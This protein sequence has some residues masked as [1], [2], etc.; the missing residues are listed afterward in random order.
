MKLTA[1]MA[2]EFQ[3]LINIWRPTCN[4]DQLPWRVIE[5]FEHEVATEAE[6][7][8]VYLA[9]Q[10]ESEWGRS[11]PAQEVRDAAF[12]VLAERA[13]KPYSWI[14]IN[15][16]QLAW[17]DRKPKF[18][19][20]TSAHNKMGIAEDGRVGVERRFGRESTFV[21]EGIHVWFVPTKVSDVYREVSRDRRRTMRR[22]P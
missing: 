10:D 1:E 7:R 13:G 19:R 4:A 5:A 14:D 6:R 17:S 22:R 2:E 12:A 3:R 15:G 20:A 8:F 11:R 18:W 16:S 9:L 21:F